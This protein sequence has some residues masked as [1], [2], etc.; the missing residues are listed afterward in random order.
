M[1][2]QVAFLRAINVGGHIVKME[3]LRAIFESLGLDDVETFI[4][5][6]NV[7]FS[8]A[9]GTTV[10]L[11]R[12]IEAGL[13]KELGY[14]VETF[15]RTNAELAEISEHRP[16][17]DPSRER[18]ATRLFIGFLAA[19]PSPEAESK[20]L[21]AGGETDE[22]HI[23]GREIYWHCHVPANESKFYGGKLEKTLGM[24]TTLRNVNT[25]RRL[26]AKY[27]PG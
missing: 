13:Q 17:F 18:P 10:A 19:E 8:P 15:V 5:S 26:V 4:A 16:P 6:G 22:F 27:P 7:V 20:L 12:K 24:A 23:H 3:R 1:Q 21:S 9:R 11:E 25:V 14:E 2:R